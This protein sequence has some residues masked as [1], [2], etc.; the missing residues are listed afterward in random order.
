MKPTT[1]E[2]IDRMIAA[3]NITRFSNED[4]RELFLS[5]L[6]QQDR[7]TRHACAEA[8]YS[9]SRVYDHFQGGDFACQIVMRA[10]DACM[11]TQSV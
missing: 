10:H 4:L 7:D 6:T 8:V 2:R 5:E 1:Q 3:A 11:N 9:I